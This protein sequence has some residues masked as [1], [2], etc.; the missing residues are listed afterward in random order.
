MSRNSIVS[1]P[2]TTQRNGCSG[3]ADVPYWDFDYYAARGRR[4]QAHAMGT[5]ASELLRRVFRSV[6]SGRLS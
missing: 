4:L 2:G 1:L 6:R 3:P 5:A